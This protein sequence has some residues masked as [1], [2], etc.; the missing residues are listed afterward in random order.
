MFKR[1]EFYTMKRIILFI[2]AFSFTITSF[3]QQKKELKRN[4]SP[5]LIEATYYYDN[6]QIEFVWFYKKIAKR[7]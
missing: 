7:S 6:G 4:E 1:Q 5:N 3:S 2:A